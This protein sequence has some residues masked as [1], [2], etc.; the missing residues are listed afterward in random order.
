[1][2]SVLHLAKQCPEKTSQI[3]LLEEEDNFSQHVSSLPVLANRYEVSGAVIPVNQ[4]EYLQY[5]VPHTDKQNYFLPEYY[6]NQGFAC[7]NLLKKDKVSSVCVTAFVPDKVLL[8]SFLEGL[9]LSSYKFER[10]K[11]NKE[12]YSLQEITVVHPEIS[13]DDLHELQHLVQAVFFARDLV[14]EPGG[15]LSAEELAGAIEQMG[16]ASGFDTNILDLTQISS[17]KMG[18]LLGVNAGSEEPPTFSVLTYKPDNA[19]NDRPFVLVGKG[20]T[21]DTGGYSLKPPQ[22]MLYM[23]SDMGGAAAVAG[24]MAAVASNNLPIYVVGLVP[25]TDNRVDGNALVPGDVIQISDGSTVEVLNTD[26]EGRLILADALT[27]AKKY[28]PQL[29]I[30]LAT[31]TGAAKAAI[32]K[33]GMVMM[34]SGDPLFKQ[35]LQ[36]SGE[37]VYERLVEFPLWDEYREYLK[38]DVADLKNIGKREAGAITAGM[39]LKHFT[40]YNWIHLDIAGTAFLTEPHTYRGMN[41]TGSGVRLLYDFLKRKAS[42]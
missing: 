32:G 25:S 29:V 8:L 5:L 9:A 4:P 13:D 19:I 7:Y 42:H 26:A 14:N 23:K 24:A 6:R 1:M 37:Q 35:D 3:I 17:L 12:P 39:F 41:G 28:D 16:Q 15:K 27:Y 36:A 33:E 2:E 21:Y 34:G 11:K 22:G 38:S 40:N 30:D 31:L 20:V 18:G 10:Y